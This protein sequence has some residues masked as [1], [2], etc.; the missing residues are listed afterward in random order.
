MASRD[1]HD[2][3]LWKKTAD[4]GWPGLTIPEQYGGLGLAWEDLIVLAEET[5]RSLFPS[6]LR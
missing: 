4:L 5:G 6:P 2:S 1:P 3:G